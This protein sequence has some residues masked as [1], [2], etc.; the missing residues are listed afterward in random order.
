[1]NFITQNQFNSVFHKLENYNYSTD[2]IQLTNRGGQVVLEVFSEQMGGRLIKLEPEGEFIDKFSEAKDCLE[3]LEKNTHLIGGRDLSEIKVRILMGLEN[4][5]QQGIIKRR[6]NELEDLGNLFQ[7]IDL[8]DREKKEPIY[9]PL[10]ELDRKIR[11]HLAEPIPNG[12][13]VNVVD[14]RYQDD[15]GWVRCGAHAL[16]NA[17]VGL[18]LAVSPNV[19][20]DWFTRKD[21]F[22]DLLHFIYEVNG[23]D[24]W[25]RNHPLE[26]DISMG[27]LQNA[28]EV[29][30]HINPV[31]LNSKNLEEFRLICV[32]HPQM[33]TTL[34]AFH[35]Q[36]N[37][38]GSLT[39]DSMSH[40]YELS[41]N[42]GPLLHAFAVGYSIPDPKN[43]VASEQGH[44][45][46][47]ILKKEEGKE[48]SW[49]A[50]DSW[51]NQSNHSIEM[52]KLL[53]QT[54]NNIDPVITEMYRV[55]VA[56]II[57]EN[58][59][60]AQLN[61]FLNADS[62]K[63]INPVSV[64]LAQKAFE[65]MSRV[66]WL[67]KAKLDQN[68]LLKSYVENLKGFAEYMS[69]DEPESDYHP[70]TNDERAVFILIAQE[71]AGVV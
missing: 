41:K 11:G 31:Q 8:E 22:E 15:L 54:M 50:A 20:P 42:P 62:K 4:I 71:T 37:T 24:E 67:N 12:R 32:N 35:G 53:I 51:E 17:L 39:L 57:E 40:L 58:F 13:M 27:H 34:Q 47:L 5:E 64:K 23:I 66:G 6:F 25:L 28:L 45:V 36:F 3:F 18:G 69:V 1:M 21:V 70:V 59:A 33:I 49:I 44:W 48:L 52:M 26:A 38:F 56:E 43:P 16:K 9:S 2:Q 19:N 46:T 61:S 14:Q 29:L 60:I 30:I 68:P 55:G 65:F 10:Q 7:I 63:K